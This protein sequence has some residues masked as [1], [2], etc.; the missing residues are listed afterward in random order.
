[1]PSPKPLLLLFDG[2]ALIHRAYHALPALSVTKT[3]EPTGAVYGFASMLLKV[4]ADFKPTHWAI[5]LDSPG[6]TFRHEKFEQYKAHRPPAPDELKMQIK[7]VKDLIKTFNLPSFEVPGYE[8]DDIIGT[9]CKRASEQG[10]D[11]IIVTGDTD[12]LQLVSPHV[13]VLT[14]RPG[15]RFSDTVIYDKAAV[16]ERYE[17]EPEQLTDLKGLK[18]DPSD[19]IPGV[20]GIGEKTATKLIKEFGSIEGIYQHLDEVAPPKA[21]EALRQNERAAQQ[22]KELV[23]I[24]ADVPIEF[25]LDDCRV[26]SY[27]RSKVTELFRELEFTTLLPKLP[28]AIGTAAEQEVRPAVEAQVSKEAINYRIADTADALEE[29]IG[30]LSAARSFTFD[31]ETSSLEPRQTALVGISLSTAPGR[32]WYLPV[33]HSSGR[34]LPLEQGIGR[35]KPLLEDPRIT[36]IAHNG[37]YDMTVLHRYD[38]RVENLSFDT[39]IAAYL[40]GE[41]SLGLKPLAFAKLGVEMSPITSLIGTGAKQL[42]MAW[43]DI[44][45]VAEYACADADM[46]NRL[47]KLLETELRNQGLWKL[48][49]EV[50]M[51]LLP[52]LL[53]TENNGVALDTAMLRDMSWGM[54]ERMSK[55][56]N[57]IYKSVGHAFNI[58][59][60]QQL[61][62]VLYE[63]IKLPKTRKTKS[64]YSTEASVLEALKGVHPIIELLLEYRQLSKLKS[65]Y[66]DALPGLINPDTGR[67]HTTF[68]QTGTTTGRLSSSDPNLQNIPVRTEEG[69]QVRKAFIAG[70]ESSI[71][72]GADYSQIDLRVLAHLSQDPR[73]LEAFSQG[74]D[75]HAATASEVFSV[76]LSGVNKDMRRL[77]KTINFGVIYGMSEYGLEQATE[78]SRQEAAQFIKAYFEK[79]SGVKEYLALTKKEAAEKGYV[80]TLLG[81]R[82][83]IP[84]VNSANAQVRMAAERMAINMPVQGTSADII[85]VAM[86]ELQHEMDK[87]RLEAK[88]ILQVHDELLFELPKEETEKL[89]EL[90]LRIMP[91]AVKLSVPVKVDIKTGKS[92][93]DME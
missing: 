31:V 86:I 21:Q 53:R 2:H 75:I 11:T 3:G 1:M 88:M 9:I 18:G 89:T 33:G 39:M 22:S 4:L 68:N 60:P 55:L 14:P 45:R 41:K 77:A 78:L 69:R 43:V 56:E 26:T 24:D 62:A 64:G 5:A 67:V 57:E 91:V 72:M 27:E 81:R 73:L 25:N 19:N 50:E 90:V 16:Q 74:E 65:T 42:S 10:T 28:E 46:T 79:Y 71:L 82:R 51:P 83:Y 12:T 37:K 48:F 44:P 34:Q 6:P 32:A 49:A 70:K 92:W 52:V 40:L 29:I 20:P 61:G 93:G 23:T 85:K 36:K 35:L 59:S 84:E 30:A 47:S 7:R 80:Q 17:L 58:N 13:R 63:E 87:E 15:K 38:V 66:I 54:N 76:P 8:A